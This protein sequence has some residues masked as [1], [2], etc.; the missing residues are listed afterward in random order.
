MIM[1]LAF[2]VVVLSVRLIC[3]GNAVAKVAYTT[4]AIGVI[5]VADNLNNNPALMKSCLIVA[6]SFLLFMIRGQ[7]SGT[8]RRHP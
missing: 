4:L 2:V 7:Y 3:Q 6:L 1:F 8:N 5:G